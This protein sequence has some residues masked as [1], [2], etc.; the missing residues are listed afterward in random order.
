VELS[1][2]LRTIGTEVA[3][4]SIFLRGIR[5]IGTEVAPGEGGSIF[6]RGIRTIGTEVATGEGERINW[7]L[8]QV[9]GGLRTIGTEV[10][11]GEG[12][13]KNWYLL[14][15]FGGLRTIGTEV[16]PGEGGS[17]GVSGALRTIRTEVASEEGRPI[18]PLGALRT[19]RT[20]VAP[21]ERRPIF[22][23]VIRTVRTDAGVLGGNG[24]KSCSVVEVD[25]KEKSEAVAIAPPVVCGWPYIGGLD[26]AAVGEGKTGESGLL[27]ERESSIADN[28][29]SVIFKIPS[30]GIHGSSDW[31]N[32]DK[33]MTAS[34]GDWSV[35]L[36]DE[37]LKSTT[38]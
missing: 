27:A 37:L 2:P 35:G 38:R 11:P 21:R 36:L 6:L 19:V 28:S 32:K 5:T 26:V 18:Y 20:E 16:A 25:G 13:R 15:V 3:L 24:W 14:R 1:G 12:E 9:F 10:A 29:S 31:S 22:P 17:V 4:E 23:L 8:L 33:S 30:I 7:Y 34:N